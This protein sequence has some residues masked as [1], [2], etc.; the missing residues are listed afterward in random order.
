[1][2][3]IPDLFEPLGFDRQQALRGVVLASFR[4]RAFAIALDSLIIFAVAALIGAADSTDRTIVLSFGPTID[5]ENLYGAGVSTLYFTLVTYFGNGRTIGKFVFQIRVISLV[6]ER[7]PFWHSLDRALGY[8][9]SSVVA[10]LGFV[11]YFTRPNH[12]TIHDRLAQTIVVSDP[13]RG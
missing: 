9:L 2:K 11:Q 12:Q 13:R 7:L 8:A 10:G 6:A 4:A 3:R 1:M 5:L